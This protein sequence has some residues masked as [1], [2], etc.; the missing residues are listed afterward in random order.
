MHLK[1]SFI[2]CLVALVCLSAIMAF[3]FTR[4][5]WGMFAYQNAFIAALT[6]ECAQ[7]QN[8]LRAIGQPAPT[9]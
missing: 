4:C 1:L 3:S 6:K 8:E 2:F 9:P 5:G 7:Q